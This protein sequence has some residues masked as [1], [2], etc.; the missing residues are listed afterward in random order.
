MVKNATLGVNSIQK[1]IGEA[2]QNLNDAILAQLPKLNINDWTLC[3]IYVNA[4]AC[5]WYF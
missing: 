1:I 3:T 4:M 5:R 2:T